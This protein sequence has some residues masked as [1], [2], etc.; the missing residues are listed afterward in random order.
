MEIELKEFGL[1][2]NEVKVY[3][4]LLKTGISTANRISELTGV[5]RST[6]YD[7]LKL[8]AVKGI[9]STHIKEGK[10]FFESAHP[11]KILELLKYKEERI[12]IS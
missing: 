8:L 9:I 5:K 4:T 11:S 10:N 7:T 6:T 3:L 2:D 1:S 12:K